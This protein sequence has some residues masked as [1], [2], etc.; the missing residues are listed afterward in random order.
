M[1]SVSTLIGILLSSVAM[2]L[3]ML[4]STEAKEAAFVDTETGVSLNIE[5]T[6]SPSDT[7]FPLH[8]SED[9]QVLLGFGQ[10]VTP[11]PA[12]NPIDPP[13]RFIGYHTAIDFEI[14]DGE[15]STEVPVHAIA[16]GEI[17]FSGEVSGYGGVIIQSAEINGQEVTVLYGHMQISSLAT[18]GTQLQQGD[19][20]GILATAESPDSGYTRKHLHLSIHKGTEIEFLGYVQTPDELNA[21]IDP[22]TVLPL[23]S[24]SGVFLS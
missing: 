21:F 16:D 13:E 24:R 1:Q 12:Q 2:L 19:S 14:L 23:L 6:S 8:D 22:L 20:L 11:D 18:K 3:G 10:Y 5:S 9:R 15:E 17:L 4:G 7:V